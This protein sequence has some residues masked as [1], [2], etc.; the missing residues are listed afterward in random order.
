MRAL[1]LYMKNHERFS[2]EDLTALKAI[3]EGKLPVAEKE[4]AVVLEAD[5]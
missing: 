2:A 1:R 3:F 5:S 4:L